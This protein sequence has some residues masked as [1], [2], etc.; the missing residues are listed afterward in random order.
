[1]LAGVYVHARSVQIVFAGCAELNSP[2]GEP[3]DEYWKIKSEL[4]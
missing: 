1:M 2:K 3:G 4:C